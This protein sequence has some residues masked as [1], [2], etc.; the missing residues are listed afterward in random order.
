MKQVDPKDMA[1]ALKAFARDSA[2][3]KS[4]ATEWLVFHSYL[5]DAETGRCGISPPMLALTWD[6]AVVVFNSLL[7]ESLSKMSREHNRA[8]FARLTNDPDELRVGVF[9][10]MLT[11]EGGGT[12]PLEAM[13]I[14]DRRKLTMDLYN[15]FYAHHVTGDMSVLE[16]A[17]PSESY[18]PL[19]T[20]RDKAV[21][22]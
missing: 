22:H 15:E 8:Y 20:S 16:I 21:L 10:E 2:L 7:E 5:I 6:V 9:P 11:P 14:M 4:D 1:S 3:A 12:F 17:D 19:D 18:S 13:M